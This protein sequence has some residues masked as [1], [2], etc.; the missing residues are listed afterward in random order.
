MPIVQY[1]Q[2]ACRLLLASVFVVAVFSKISEKTAWLAFVQSLRQLRQVPD[3]VVRAAALA[4]VAIEMLVAVLLLV[5][6]PAAGAFGFA[7]A[8]CLLLAFTIAIGLAL[9]RGN[10]V[11]CRCFGASSTPLGLPHVTRNLVLIC[12]ATLGLIGASAAGTLDVA[13]AALA[14]A[15]G[16]IVGI[17]VTALEDVVA[18]FKPA[19]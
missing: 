11:P 4:T 13:Y 17:L 15:S 18:L 5:P 7:L 12:V 8:A 3:A 1:L 14:G 10:R 2:V 19:G 9:L 6:V 16:L